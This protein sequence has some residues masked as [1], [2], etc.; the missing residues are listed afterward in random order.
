MDTFN[1]NNLLQRFFKHF[2][3]FQ[4]SE[5]FFLSFLW[6]NHFFRN[7]FFCIFNWVSYILSFFLRHNF[8]LLGNSAIRKIF[9]LTS[10]VEDGDSNSFEL[11]WRLLMYKIHLLK[12]ITSHIHFRSKYHVCGLFWKPTF[13][14]VFLRHIRKKSLNFLNILRSSKT[15]IISRVKDIFEVSW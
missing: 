15:I 14:L 8:L 9:A 10:I 12:W 13:A 2:K 1:L 5:S 4:S 6:L 3:A 11:W 7:L